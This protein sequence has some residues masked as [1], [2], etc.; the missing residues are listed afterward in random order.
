MRDSKSQPASNRKRTP[1]RQPLEKNLFSYAAAA[2]AAGVAL[3]ACS[4][5][6]DASVVAKK[7][8]IALPINGGLIQFDI[9][10]D[11]QNDFGLSAQALGG[12]T[13]TT[14]AA[15]KGKHLRKPPLGCPFD[16]RVNVVP[17]QAADEV[18]KSGSFYGNNCAA[19]I[20]GGV[21]IGAARPFVGG[22]LA[23]AVH[24]GT[25]EGLYFC[26]WTGSSA[27]HPYLAVKFTDTSGN[28]HFGWVR[29]TVNFAFLA[30]VTGYGYETVPNRPILAG[31]T[32]GADEHASIV[33]PQD[34][35]PMRQEVASLGRLAQG[36]SGLSAW[37]REEELTAR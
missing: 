8:N 24:S 36:A 3:L 2:G 4:A 14:S 9:N 20:A 22:K 5:P 32:R 31:A 7:V 18:W 13:S 25:S 28:V 21:K 10:G 27:P 15:I 34:L 1:L 29:V 37:R 17:T 30:T 33:E 23:M 26:P 16:D 35:T 12:C 6:A 11:G 19:D